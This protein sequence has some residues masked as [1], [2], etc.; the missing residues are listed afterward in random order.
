MTLG[1]AQIVGFISV[2]VVEGEPL[3][4]FGKISLGCVGISWIVT[5]LYFTPVAVAMAKNKDTET[6]LE[7]LETDLRSRTTRCSPLARGFLTPSPLLIQ[8]RRCLLLVACCQGQ[9]S[10]KKSRESRDSKIQSL[11]TRAGRGPGI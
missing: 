2:V 11:A 10:R 6:Q 8:N 7:M 4:I 9:G 3:E 5:V 1:M